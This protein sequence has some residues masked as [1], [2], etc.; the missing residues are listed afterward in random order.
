[1]SAMQYVA[2]VLP[3]MQSQ[4]EAVGDLRHRAQRCRADIAQLADANAERSSLEC[5]LQ[6]L[7]VDIRQVRCMPCSQ[8]PWP[9]HSSSCIAGA[10][11][12]QTL[13][14]WRKHACSSRIHADARRLGQ[15]G[16][17]IVQIRQ[18]N[19]SRMRRVTH[20][21]RL[22]AAKRQRLQDQWARLHDAEGDSGA[23]AA[24]LELSKALRQEFPVAAHRWGDTLGALITRR[25]QLVVSTASL[26]RL[27]PKVRA[28][29]IERTR[30]SCMARQRVQMSARMDRRL[31]G[32]AI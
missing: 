10:Q 8:V 2:I 13:H 1:M 23:F 24:A 30:E 6:R 4:C 14:L 12:A 18:L 29:P 26:F 5:Q 31:C 7:H 9:L 16:S 27:G 22:V 21:R 28:N 11:C 19:D 32:R 25:H 17:V 20:V 3:Q 15:A